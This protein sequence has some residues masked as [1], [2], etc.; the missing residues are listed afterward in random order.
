M[1]C[2]LLSGPLWGLGALNIW[3]ELL[4]AAELAVNISYHRDTSSIFCIYLSPFCHV[5]EIYQACTLFSEIGIFLGVQK[6]PGR[7]PFHTQGPTTSKF[8][9]IVEGKWE[10]LGAFPRQNSLFNGT[11]TS[12]VPAKNRINVFHHQFWNGI[13][14]HTTTNARG[15]GVEVAIKR[16]P[17]RRL[18]HKATTSPPGQ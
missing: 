3:N 2:G 13:P 18:D 6:V 12:L 8:G 9:E 1:W 15:V 14:G 10:A 4:K 11:G 16:L 7:H 5:S 17:A